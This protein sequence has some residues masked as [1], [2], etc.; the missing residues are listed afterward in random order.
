MYPA[1]YWQKIIKKDQEKD[2]ETW[3]GSKYLLKEFIGCG[4]YGAVFRADEMLAERVMQTVAIK[5]VIVDLERLDQQIEELQLAVR[6]RHPHL[7]NGI[8]CEQ[9]DVNGDLCIGLVM[10]LAD[11]SL[12]SYLKVSKPPL[13]V[14]FVST[15]VQHLA[16]GLAYIH[17]QGIIHRDLKPA[18]IL[19]VGENWKLADFGIARS[20][21]DGTSTYTNPS[22]QIGTIAYMPPESYG[23]RISSAWDLWSLGVM[24]HDLLSNQHPFPSNIVPEL[25]QMVLSQEPILSENLG[26]P[27]REIVTG[28]LIKEPRD[29]WTAQQVLKPLQ[30]PVIQFATPQASPSPNPQVLIL[31]LPNN[32]KLEMVKIPAGSFLMGSAET[33]VKRLNK[34]Y[35]TDWYNCELPQHRVT[36]QEYYLGKYP[37]TQEQY[38][39]VM[40]NNPSHFKDNPKN[41]VENVSWNDT[42]TFCQKVYEKTGEK[43]R[44]P[45]EAEWEYG[46]RAGTQSRYYFGDDESQLGNYAWYGDNSG[47]IRLNSEKLWIDEPDGSKYWEKLKNNNSQSHPIGE[48]DPNQWGLYDM[49]GNVWEWCEDSWHENYKE[50]PENL[51]QDGSIIWSSSNESRHVLRGGSWFD[52]LPWDCRSANR[53]WDNAD[54]GCSG[55]FGFRLVLFS[56]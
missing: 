11:D 15:L 32:I 28:C 6:L 3:F 37:V 16:D 49:H 2:Q 40:G 55:D 45:T 25:I 13:A 23:G 22:Q 31:D 21:Q 46:C 54:F 42:K 47:K 43:V 56:L 24:I 5:I 35:S 33:E 26:S 44:L 27:F 19:R 48:K 34:E 52:F 29:R 14:E 36:L 51:K 8:T 41:P 17:G 9:G 53:N 1:S 7:I 12:E 39:A 50:K 30:P 18:N 10:E 4:A 38:Q 20:L